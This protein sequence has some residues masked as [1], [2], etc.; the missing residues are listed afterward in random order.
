[1][2]KEL[3]ITLKEKNLV[4]R[5]TIV[6]AQLPRQGLDGMIRFFTNN[7]HYNSSIPAENILDIEG[8]TPDRFAKSYNIKSN[9][10]VK[11]Q[12][13]RGRKSKAA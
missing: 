3:L 12:K 2:N 10:V 8:M 11:S 7:V 6:K 9:G 13:K 1:M 5:N 4:N